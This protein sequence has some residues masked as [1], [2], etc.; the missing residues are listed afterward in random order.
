MSFCQKSKGWCEEV[1]WIELFILIAMGLGIYS[2]LCSEYG[3]TLWWLLVVTI[4]VIVAF[5]DNTSQLRNKGF[6]AVRIAAPSNILEPVNSMSVHVPNTP[7]GCRV[8]LK[9]AT[10]DRWVLESPST[11]QPIA[12]ATE[13]SQLS[14]IQDWC[15]AAPKH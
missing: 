9:R 3:T 5:T 10:E 15:E 6:D 11:N 13:L 7:K 1:W 8:G 4:L 2:F 14:S 12:K